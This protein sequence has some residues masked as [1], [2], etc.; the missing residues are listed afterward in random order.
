MSGGYDY[1]EEPRI[2]ENRQPSDIDDRDDTIDRTPRRSFARQR[3][4]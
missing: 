2:R 1:G 3:L 4:S